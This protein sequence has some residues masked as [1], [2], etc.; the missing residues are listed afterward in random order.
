MSHAS[1]SDQKAAV[2]TFQTEVER[3]VTV[4][5]AAV[6]DAI[7]TFEDGVLALQTA[8]ETKVTDFSTT[9]QADINKIFDDAAASCS[10]GKSGQ[11]IMTQI[12]AAMEAKKAARDSDKAAHTPGEQFKAL[13]ATRKA[14]VDTAMAAFKTGFTAATTELKKSFTK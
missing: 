4:R 12:K 11:E 3:L 2:T 5:K 14:S 10:A 6:D 7:K 8:N 13:Q 1:T 9:M